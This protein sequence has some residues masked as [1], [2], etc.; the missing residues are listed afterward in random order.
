MFLRVQQELLCDPS[1]FFCVMSDGRDCRRVRKLSLFSGLT[2]GRRTSSCFFFS[3]I[4]RARYWLAHETQT[5]PKSPDG[6]TYTTIWARSKDRD[7]PFFRTT[8]AWDAALLN[9]S[10]GLIYSPPPSPPGL[11]VGGRS[12]VYDPVPCPCHLDVTPRN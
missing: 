7:Q 3:V 10:C 9:C 4:P 5:S 2:A 6:G 12:L 11:S 1:F 8:F